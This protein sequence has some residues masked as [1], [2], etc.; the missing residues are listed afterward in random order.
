MMAVNTKILAVL[1]IVC[2]VIIACVV[3]ITVLGNNKETNNTVNHLNGVVLEIKENTVTNTGLTLIMKNGTPD[4]Y[5][6]GNA[7]YFGVE[8]KIADNWIHVPFIVENP[9][10]T[11]EPYILKAGSTVEVEINWKWFH[12]ELSCGTYRITYPIGGL[13]SNEFTI[14][15]GIRGY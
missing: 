15:M 10:S 7:A 5:V 2:I 8:E 3:C 14:D 11:S 13:I 4:E 1:L 12:G 9:V 6:Y